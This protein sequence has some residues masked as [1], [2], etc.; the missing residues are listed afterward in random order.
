MENYDI[1]PLQEDDCEF[2]CVF[3]KQTEQAID[4]FYFYQDADEYKSFLSEGGAFDGFTP[5]FML[6]E[7]HVPTDPN[8]QF[9]REFL[10]M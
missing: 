9:S 7:V 8:E 4:F 1:I 6:K 10:D 2:Y 3:E 5:S